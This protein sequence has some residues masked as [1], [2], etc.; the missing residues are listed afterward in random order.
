MQKAVEL[1]QSTNKNILKNLAVYIFK[2]FEK[3]NEIL[4]S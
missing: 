2:S 4:L 1:L 3:R